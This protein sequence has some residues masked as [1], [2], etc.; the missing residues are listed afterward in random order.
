MVL[1]GMED[2]ADNEEDA[3]SVHSLLSGRSTFIRNDK[4]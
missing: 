3:Q 4:L 1:V 2:I